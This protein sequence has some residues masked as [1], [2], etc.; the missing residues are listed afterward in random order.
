M[1]VTSRVLVVGLILVLAPRMATPQQ[2]AP[3]TR[4]QMETFLAKAKIVNERTT[5][6]GVTRPIRA[7]LSDG[8][9]THDAQFQTVDQAKAIFEAGK[10]SEVD[11]KDSYRYNI[12]GYRLAQ[13]VGIETVPVS[14]KRSYKG[15]DAAITWWIDDVMFDESGRMELKD[16]S[17]GPDPQ[18]TQR[19]L[20][21]MR[22]WDELIQNKDRNRGNLLW[23]KDWT[24]W[25]IDHTRAFRT[26]AAL[27]K[28][29]ELVRIERTLFDK[30]KQL[31]EPSMTKAMSGMLTR[32]EIRSVLRRR[33][34]IVQHFEKLIAERGDAAVLF[35]LLPPAAA[36]S[37]GQSTGQ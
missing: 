19:Q 21:M 7:T 10:A 11:F 31:T 6:V 17:M 20:H 24:M 3:L 37:A 28:P 9:L 27:L 33:D 13:L 18:R 2:T 30:L 26:G 1:A 15:K 14:V 8:V 35:T 4:E 22:V 34:A 23:T 25:L 32:N 16:Q 29:A 5:S 36:Q 12:A